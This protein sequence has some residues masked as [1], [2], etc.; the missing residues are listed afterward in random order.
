MTFD[1]RMMPQNIAGFIQ[2]V[3]YPSLLEAGINFKMEL[4]FP[5]CVL[6]EGFIERLENECHALGS[7]L[8]INCDGVVFDLEG[9]VLPCNHFIAY[10]M[11]RY[12][13]DFTTPEEFLHWRQSGEVAKFY[14]TTRLAPGKRCAKCDKWSK[15]GAGCRLYWL[16]RGPNELL[17]VSR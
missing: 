11:G 13:V 1:D 5:Q 2:D 3:M 14:Q 7:C 6:R 12:G 10:T 15:C 9:N 17:P 4:M 8:L 16:Y